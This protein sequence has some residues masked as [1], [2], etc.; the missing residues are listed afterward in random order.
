MFALKFG[1]ENNQTVGR[2]RNELK[3]S[4]AH[5]KVES[6][7]SWKQAGRVNR[8]SIMLHNYIFITGLCCKR[9]VIV[10]HTPPPGVPGRPN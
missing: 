7:L 1:K 2:L 8:S 3:C 9:F 4:K 5:N 10:E 6:Q